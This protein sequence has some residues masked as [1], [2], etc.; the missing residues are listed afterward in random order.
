MKKYLDIDWTFSDKGHTFMSAMVSFLVVTRTSIAYTRFTE[1]RDFL[2]KAMFSTRELIQHIICFTRY[3][4]SGGAKKWRAEI[5]RRSIVLLR[6]LVCIL[7]YPSKQEQVVKTS[8]LT[9]DEVQALLMAVGG[10]NERTPLVLIIF[11]R[12]VIMSNGDY[13]KEPIH[14]NKELRL[15]VFVS[16]FVSAYHGL[17]KLANTPFP[18]PLVQM[19]RT[20]L[21]VWVFSLPLAIMDDIIRLPALFLIIFFVTYGFVGLEYVAMELDDPFG[22]DPNDFDV[23]G[24]SEVVFDDIFIAV[25]DIDGKEAADNLRRNVNMPLQQLTRNTVRSH[26]RFSSVSAWKLAARD[27]KEA[28]ER[29]LKEKNS[30]TTTGV[31]ERKV[32]S[33]GLSRSKLLS[34]KETEASSSE[35]SR[36]PGFAL[37]TIFQDISMR[38]IDASM[39]GDEAEKHPLISKDK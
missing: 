21:F 30:I 16:D 7:E 33:V 11:L 8:E 1:A 35:V 3:D 24:L 20:F 23:R 34:P 17:N 31:K 25:H 18:F 36:P 9:I 5:A 15:L 13:L 39:A 28:S 14:V 26:Q 27:L 19:T 38:T 2:D 29:D 10:S 22:D 4:D 32:S 12:T 6:T 37:D